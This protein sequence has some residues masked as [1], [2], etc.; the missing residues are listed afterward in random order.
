LPSGRIGKVLVGSCY[1][2]T[3]LDPFGE[4]TPT[5]KRFAKNEV[6]F[7]HLVGG[8]LRAIWSVGDA[9]GLR[10]QRW[11]GWP[12]LDTNRL[13]LLLNRPNSRLLA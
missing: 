2:G 11:P 6:A 13:A 7:F 9:L 5:C 12:A 10:I 8:Q 3:H 4:I 1:T